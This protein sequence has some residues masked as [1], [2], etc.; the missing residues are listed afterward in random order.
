MAI[1]NALVEKDMFE[2]PSQESEEEEGEDEEEELMPD[3]ELAELN[4]ESE[5][6]K[7]VEFQQILMMESMLEEL[8]NEWQ[9]INNYSTKEQKIIW[10]ITVRQINDSTARL[11][12]FV[13]GSS[14]HP[15]EHLDASR[16]IVLL[17]EEVQEKLEAP[18]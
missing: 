4:P 16:R 1:S 18:I 2:W 9:G 8:K 14:T 7:A 3:E 6:L 5:A 12:R 15:A 11:K 10:E 17:I 13:T